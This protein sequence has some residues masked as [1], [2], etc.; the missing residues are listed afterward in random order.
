MNT[1]L[2]ECGCSWSSTGYGDREIVNIVVCDKHRINMAL[3]MSNTV[4]HLQIVASGMEDKL[5]YKNDLI[6]EAKSL[7]EVYGHIIKTEP[8][9]PIFMKM[10]YQLERAS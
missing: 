2:L 1:C 5:Y 9:F 8:L 10:L 7:I 6:K 3:S 4:G